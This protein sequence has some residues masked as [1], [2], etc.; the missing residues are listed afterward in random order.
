VPRDNSFSW[1]GLARRANHIDMELHLHRPDP[2]RDN[3]QITV[4]L[5]P[6]SRNVTNDERWRT[7]CIQIFC[8][9]RGYLMG[10]NGAAV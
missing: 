9:L 10:Q 6:G 2:S 8:D 7:R 4:V 1:F 3:L 5:R